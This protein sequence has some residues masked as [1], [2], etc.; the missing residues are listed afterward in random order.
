MRRLHKKMRWGLRVRCAFWPIPATVLVFVAVT[1]S[2]E[3]IIVRPKEIS[4]VLVNPGMGITTFQRYN[5]DA[6]NEGL[7]WSEAGPTAP[8]PAPPEKPDFPETSVAYLRWHWSTLEPA[9]GT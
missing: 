7:K 4:G 3:K 2:G 6:L 9:H 8:L 1:A 5:G